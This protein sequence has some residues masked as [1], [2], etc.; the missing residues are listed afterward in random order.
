MIRYDFECQQISPQ[1]MQIDAQ[2]C[3][4][5]YTTFDTFDLAEMVLPAMHI[6]KAEYTFDKDDFFELM[7][8]VRK[9]PEITDMEEDDGIYKPKL[10]RKSQSDRYMQ[11]WKCRKNQRNRAIFK[12]YKS[13][14][15]GIFK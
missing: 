13:N 2:A 1:E 5:N 11:G 9:G 8:I 14:A 3:V 15:Y 12:I 7:E 10:F 6:Y 4:C